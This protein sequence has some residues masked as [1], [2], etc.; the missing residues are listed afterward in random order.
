MK[1]TVLTISLLFV[2]AWLLGTAIFWLFAVT[3]EAMHDGG[4]RHIDLRL[5]AGLLIIMFF[6]AG[7]AFCIP[8]AL[9]SI[10]ASAFL[11]WPR[12]RSHRAFA[13][14]TAGT[15][16]IIFYVCLLLHG[17]YM[18]SWLHSIDPPS[19]V[20]R[21]P[22]ALHALAIAPLAFGGAAFITSRILRKPP[23]VTPSSSHNSTR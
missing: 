21:S 20:P 13:V 14:G 7:L 19:L 22:L 23:P 6:G 12:F 2:L 8:G 16:I 10:C 1:R 3:M 17:I 5:S 9:T 18:A 15:S 11:R 4:S